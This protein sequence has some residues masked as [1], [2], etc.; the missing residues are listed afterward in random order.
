MDCWQ[1]SVVTVM[2]ASVATVTHRYLLTFNN[3]TYSVL[4]GVVVNVKQHIHIS[5]VHLLVPL[6]GNDY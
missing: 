4:D 3:H 5:L 6:A 2:H 1:T